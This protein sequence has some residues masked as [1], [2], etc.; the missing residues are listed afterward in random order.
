MNLSVGIR[1]VSNLQHLITS[2]KL[3]ALGLE[4]FKFDNLGV[5]IIRVNE[6]HYS[7]SLMVNK[8]PTKV[9][10][11]ILHMSGEDTPKLRS[12]AKNA[13][14]GSKYERELAKWGTKIRNAGYFDSILMD[15]SKCIHCG[16]FFKV[17]TTHEHTKMC[18]DTVVHHHRKL[19]AKARTHKL[20]PSWRSGIPPN[21]KSL[22]EL[23]LIEQYIIK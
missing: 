16:L 4:P 12:I 3:R 20:T 15:Y 7:V 2:A 9:V 14:K 1:F 18:D 8:D 21:R 23:G 6:T 10:W 17:G 19:Y 11:C 5:F 22:E 13:F